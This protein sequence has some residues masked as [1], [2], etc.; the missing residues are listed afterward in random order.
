MKKLIAVAGLLI[1]PIIA[2]SSGNAASAK[3]EQIRESNSVS[4]SSDLAIMTYA[5]SKSDSFKYSDIDPALLF[6]SRSSQLN[7]AIP[8]CEDV[9]DE[10]TTKSLGD[11]KRSSNIKKQATSLVDDIYK[12][13]DNA[14]DKAQRSI[15]NASG[16]SSNAA[17]V[18]PVISI[19][20]KVCDNSTS[21]GTI[22]QL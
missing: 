5:T 13:L 22:I 4:A 8:A 9:A 15:Q 10:R 3:L 1:S 2:L 7:R 16:S 17:K 20:D 11:T 19:K 12:V 18:F 6:K 21:K 14:I